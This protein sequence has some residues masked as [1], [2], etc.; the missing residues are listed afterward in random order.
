MIQLNKVGVL[1]RDESQQHPFEELAALLDQNAIQAAFLSW[2]GDPPDDLDLI[3]AMGGDGTVLKALDVGSTV[4]VLAVN[5]GTV[6]FLTAGDRSELTTIVDRLI[7]GDY[8]VSERLV[9]HCTHPSGEIRAITE[10]IVRTSSRF[11][12]VAVHVD[13]TARP[14]PTALPPHRRPGPEA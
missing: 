11:C 5:F 2:D 6:G 8:I 13:G 4:P 7:A 12:F 3:I 14:L 10:V 1:L 9:L